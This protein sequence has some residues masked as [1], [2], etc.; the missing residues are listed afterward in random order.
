MNFRTPLFFNYK[1]L[2]VSVFIFIILSVFTCDNIFEYSV[3]DADVKES[4]K[5]TTSK[6]LI[7]VKTK[8]QNSTDYFKFAVISDTH[9]YYDD[10]RAIIDDINSRPDI[11]FVIVTGDFTQ[12]GLL[13]E[14]ELFYEII[15]K[16]SKPYLTVIGNHDYLSNGENI[17][18]TMFGEN[19]Y[20]FEFKNNKFIFFDNIVWESNKIPDF[21]WL[22]NELDDSISYNNIFV[23]AHI[24]PRDEQFTDSMR[25]SYRSILEENNA[26]LSIHG[27]AHSYDFRIINNIEYLTV[28]TVNKD[29]YCI[30]NVDGSSY[31]IDLIE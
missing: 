6:N 1:F 12:Q 21:K 3:Y 17:Y 14:Y 5:N 10:L 11:L 28:S 23:F 4:Q 25:N 29:S 16:L 13:K 22:T 27:H 26:K 15:E 7:E 8:E 2:K 24:P 31:S 19:N 9:F 30:I 18:N 20:T